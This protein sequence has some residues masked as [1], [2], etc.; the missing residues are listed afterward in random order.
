MYCSLLSVVFTSAKLAVLESLIFLV[1][2]HIWQLL[3]FCGE[4]VG[5]CRKIGCDKFIALPMPCRV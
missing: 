4:G 1:C 2:L 3:K 5:V